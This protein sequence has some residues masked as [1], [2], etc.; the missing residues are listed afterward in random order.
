MK[1]LTQQRCLFLQGIIWLTSPNVCGKSGSLWM[2]KSGEERVLIGDKVLYE[3]T[4]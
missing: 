3:G 4:V 2:M 1:S